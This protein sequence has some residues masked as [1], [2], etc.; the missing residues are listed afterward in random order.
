[1][2]TKGKIKEFKP[3][4]F[5]ELEKRLDASNETL[6]EIKQSTETFSERMHNYQARIHELE[7][8]LSAKNEALHTTQQMCKTLEKRISALEDYSRK[9]EESAKENWMAKVKDILKQK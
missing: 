7:L 2:V 1:M 4:I 3:S 5:Q 6:Q 8:D 9:V